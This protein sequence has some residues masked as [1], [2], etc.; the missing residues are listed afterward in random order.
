MANLYIKSEHLQLA[1]PLMQQYYGYDWS[2]LYD[3]M[4]HCV[5]NSGIEYVKEIDGM[6]TINYVESFR[7]HKDLTF[8]VTAPYKKPIQKQFSDYFMLLD[9]D[10]DEEE[11]VTDD[12]IVYLCLTFMSYIYHKEKEDLFKKSCLIAEIDLKYQIV[13]HQKIYPEMLSLYKMI[14]ESKNK[15]HRGSP[16]TLYYKQDKLEINTASWF[17]EDMEKYFQDRFPDLTLE[18]INQLLPDNKGKAGRKFRD[19]ITNNL[20][21]GTYKLMYNHHS[22]FKNSKK[23][24]SEEICT[25]IM[26]Y[27]NYLTVPNDFVFDDIRDWLKDMIKRGYT[28]QW[29]LLW[30]N[31]FS[32]IKEK[33]PKNLYERIVQELHTYG[34]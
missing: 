32:E 31:V 34:I 19:R 13:L 28:P 6:S 21:W 18:K 7:E 11:T 23:R 27:L 1:E 9:A 15:K 12:D 26:D 29:D 3:E 2:M 4:K 22:K 8:A 17:L 14:L 10:S 33:Q 24:I 30:H 5:I 16:V 20:I 25:F